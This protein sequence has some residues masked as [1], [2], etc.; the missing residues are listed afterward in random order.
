MPN[1]ETLHPDLQIRQRDWEQIVSVFMRF[2]QIERVFL[3]GSRARGTAKPYSDIDLTLEG[4]MLIAATILEIEWALDDL[5]LP[6]QFDLSIKSQ[7]RNKDL[8]HHIQSEGKLFYE[9]SV[10]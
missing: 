5:Y 3:Y 4:S 10:A 1:Q 6:F 2:P 8:L 7:I 9:K